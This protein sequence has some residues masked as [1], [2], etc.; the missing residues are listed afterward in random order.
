[1]SVTLRLHG[2]NSGG[3]TELGLY[4]PDWLSAYSYVAWSSY[5]FCW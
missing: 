4:T 2:H 3:L 5:N 1:M